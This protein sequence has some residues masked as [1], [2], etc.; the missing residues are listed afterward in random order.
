MGDHV[1]E[2]EVGLL[3]QDCGIDSI[4][5]TY[6][7]LGAYRKVDLGFRDVKLNP[8]FIKCLFRDTSYA[9]LLFNDCRTGR[10]YQVQIP[11]TTSGTYSKRSSGINSFDPKF[12]VADGMIAYTDR[13]NIY[14]EDVVTGKKAMMT[15]GQATD[16]D[17]DAIHETL[18][19]VNITQERIY[20]KIKLN[21]KWEE[22][23]KKIKLE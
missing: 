8:K 21:G 17:Y 13:G 20:V 4:W 23:E 11:I 15:F 6:E 18:D 10:G 5:W 12:S 22:L 19:S 14:V 7:G 1:L 2:P 3:P 9:F 16:M